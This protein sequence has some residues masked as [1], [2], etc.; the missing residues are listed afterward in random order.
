[1][2]RS[3]IETVMGAVVLAVAAFFLMFVYDQ[4]SVASNGGYEV[5]A[6]FENVAGIAAGSDVRIGGLKVGTVASAALDEK[7][8]QPILS[9]SLK[10]DVQLPEDTSAAVV[11]EGLLG[12]KYIEL[13][14]G[15]MEEMLKPGDSIAV[16]A[17]SV[18]LE[19][20]IGKFMFSGGGVDGDDKEEPSK[21]TAPAA[22][23]TPPASSS[24]LD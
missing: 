15:G 4:R 1:M 10:E 6:K 21:T 7:T 16:T 11:S 3:L 12:N 9:L 13:A 17:S 5:L 18:N 22:D 19:Q 20:M 24:F 14:P 8:Y 23:K 2:G